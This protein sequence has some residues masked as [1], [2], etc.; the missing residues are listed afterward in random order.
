MDKLFIGKDGIY[1]SNPDKYGVC[2]KCKKVALE[3]LGLVSITNPITG[4]CCEGYKCAACG[5]K[6]QVKTAYPADIIS[7]L[8]R[9]D[10]CIVV[11][12]F[13]DTNSF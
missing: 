10:C 13:K 11:D 6:G 2:P 3:Y 1:I 4:W 8:K 12:L 9:A 7:D 5:A